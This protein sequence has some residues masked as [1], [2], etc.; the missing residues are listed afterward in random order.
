MSSAGLVF[1]I[2]A[3]VIILGAVGITLSS[4]VKHETQK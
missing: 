4:L 1:M 2:A 3:W